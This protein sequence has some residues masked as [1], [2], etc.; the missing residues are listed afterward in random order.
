MTQPVTP[1]VLLHTMSLTKRYR[2]SREGFKTACQ[3][4]PLPKTSS[5]FSL[6][7]GASPCTKSSTTTN[8][9]ERRSVTE[10]EVWGN[11]GV[12][13]AQQNEQNPVILRL[14]KILNMKLDQTVMEVSPTWI[15][16][17]HVT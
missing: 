6:S 8:I 4:L 1:S 3:T 12:P 15:W 10:A 9:A 11:S 7:R 5:K 13:V 16:Y 17:P 14:K 2:G